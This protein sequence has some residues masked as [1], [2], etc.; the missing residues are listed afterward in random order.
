MLRYENN[1]NPGVGGL[2][3]MNIGGMMSQTSGPIGRE[4]CVEMIVTGQIG[5]QHSQVFLF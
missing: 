2:M 4:N 1:D 5:K 3:S